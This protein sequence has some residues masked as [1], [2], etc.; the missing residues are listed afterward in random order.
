MTED[1]AKKKVCCGPPQVA[2]AMMENVSLLA[3]CAGSRC[4]AWR[5][6]HTTN[7]A[8]SRKHGFC[9]LAGKP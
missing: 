4:M 6:V 7:T 3:Y 2:A 8:V 1:E 9:G 5:W